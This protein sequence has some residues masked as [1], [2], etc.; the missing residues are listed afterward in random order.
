M[1]R[2][3]PQKSMKKN[4]VHRTALDKVGKGRRGWALCLVP[5]IKHPRMLLTSLSFLFRSHLR[6]SEN[7]A[8]LRE[9]EEASGII[10]FGQKKGTTERTDSIATDGPASYVPPPQSSQPRKR[11]A[12]GS[13]GEAVE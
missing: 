3:S 8:D 11:Q 12:K 1:M 13:L 9:R 10:F 7:L 4:C 5:A 2:K 6:D